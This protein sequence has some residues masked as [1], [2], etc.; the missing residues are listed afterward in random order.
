M[1]YINNGDMTFSEK[2]KAYGLDDNSHA[3]QAAFL[4]YDLDGDLDAYLLNNKTD[5]TGPNIIRPKRNNGQ[6]ANTDK[7][8]RNDGQFFTEVSLEA[9]IKKEGYGLWIA[10]GDINQD[11]YP[12]IYIFND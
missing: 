8:Y 2:T 11:G 12:D 7:L 1:L 6:M 4:D 3:R 5:C 9:G 10:T